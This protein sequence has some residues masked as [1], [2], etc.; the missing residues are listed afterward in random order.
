MEP[1][2]QIKK[3]LHRSSYKLYKQ[4]PNKDE[5]VQ[6]RRLRGKLPKD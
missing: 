6:E 4:C 3:F 2:A 5:Q 1:E